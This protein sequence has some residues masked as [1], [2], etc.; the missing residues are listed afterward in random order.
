M[1]LE[2]Q[3]PPTAAPESSAHE[4]APHESEAPG[5]H[6]QEPADGTTTP[7]EDVPS[8]PGEASSTT[9]PEQ[10][11]PTLAEVLLAVEELWPESLAEDWDKVGLVT[12]RP[13]QPVRRIQFAVDPTEEVVQEA[14][15][16]GVDLLITHHPLLLRGV[17][18]VAATTA[19]GRVI[20]R[21]IENGV[22]L[23]T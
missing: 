7:G 5:P 4:A 8:L 16:L 11:V 6:G 13:E 14:V 9:A 20:H 19:K 12:G 15:D 2:G 22:A 1:A 18:S 21:L 3:V 23:L 17:S 10:Q